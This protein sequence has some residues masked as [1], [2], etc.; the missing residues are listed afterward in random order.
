VPSGAP[1]DVLSGFLIENG[2]AQ[3]GRLAGLA[4][5][6]SGSLLVSEDANGVIY[7]LR[8]GADVDG[9]AVDGGDGGADAVADAPDS[10]Q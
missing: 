8:Y 7:R 10:T 9:G 5:D 3:F 1:Q 2:A 4:V 6:G